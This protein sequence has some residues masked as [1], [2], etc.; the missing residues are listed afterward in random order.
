MEYFERERESGGKRE[1]VGGERERE[2]VGE[3]GWRSILHPLLLE[4]LKGTEIAPKEKETTIHLYKSFKSLDSVPSGISLQNW[5]NGM[6]RD[7]ITFGEIE[8]E[9]RAEQRRE[10]IQTPK[11]N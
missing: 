1:R 2:K 7:V 5:R 10:I 4:K 3:R 9:S 11:I 6:T 8:E